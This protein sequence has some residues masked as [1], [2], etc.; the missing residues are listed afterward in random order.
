M[1]NRL[2][3]I[4][5]S[6]REEIAHF[7]SACD[8][9]RKEALA[10]KRGFRSMARALKK[11]E[12]IGVLAEVKRASPSA[13]PIAPDCD[14]VRQAL[15]YAEAGADAIS[16]LTDGPFFSGC[17]E[18]LRRIRQA[19]DLPLLRK[20]FVLS[21]VQLYQ[22]V[23]LGAD[24]VLLIVAALSTP[25]LRRLHA[26]ALDLGLEALVEVHDPAELDQALGV[27]A[28]LIGINNRD[29][30]TFSIDLKTS[31]R[32]A[33]AIPEDRVAVSESG[34]VSGTQA[35]H[36]RSLGI[37]AILVGEALMRSADPKA[38]L[39]EFRRSAGVRA[40]RRPLA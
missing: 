8:Q 3:Q 26:L 34:I 10:A 13:G 23:L 35:E 1:E 39:A 32:L 14:P 33:G 2:E 22:S 15:L 7:G 17:A 29:L 30:R 20:D 24:A 16:V 6:K 4:L 12:R 21:E 31:E 18:D 38:K 37:D 9:W 28:T 36:L 19:V 27:G 25:E 5:R 11:Q 40:R